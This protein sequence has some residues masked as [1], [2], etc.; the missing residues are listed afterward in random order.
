MRFAFV[1]VRNGKRTVN[2]VFV[3][4]VGILCA[5]IGT[6]LSFAIAAVTTESAGITSLT[7]L[8]P[9]ILPILVIFPPLLR[10]LTASTDDL[11][12]LDN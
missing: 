5:A 2:F 8:L 7:N 3:L 1:V 9:L 12:N 4:L 6:G 11:P 10:G